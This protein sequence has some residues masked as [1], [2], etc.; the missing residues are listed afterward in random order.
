MPALKL[1]RVNGKHI[2]I[3]K[4]K[5][6]RRNTDKLFLKKELVRSFRDCVWNKGG[7]WNWYVQTPHCL[8]FY[9]SSIIFALR[10]SLSRLALPLPLSFPWRLAWAVLVFTWGLF[11]HILWFLCSVPLSLLI[12]SSA[13]NGRWRRALWHGSPI[14]QLSLIHIS[15]PTRHS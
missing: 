14:F 7:F 8:P 2:L 11:Q 12:K 3:W 4:L 15:E 5:A 10:A 1:N 6:P 13:S 9:S